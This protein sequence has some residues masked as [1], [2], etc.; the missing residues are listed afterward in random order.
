LAPAAFESDWG[1][2]GKADDAEKG[3]VIELAQSEK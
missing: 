1:R 2:F 3:K